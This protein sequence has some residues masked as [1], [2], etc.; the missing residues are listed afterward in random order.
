MNA[1]EGS[2][3]Q[4]ANETILMSHKTRNQYK[5]EEPAQPCKGLRWGGG[6][7]KAT[8]TIRGRVLRKEAQ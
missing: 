5:E 2:R 8:E 1:W 6:G 3:G 4:V 7:T